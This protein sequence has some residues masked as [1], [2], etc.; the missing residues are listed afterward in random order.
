MLVCDMFL[1]QAWTWTAFGLA[2]FTHLEI[3]LHIQINRAYRYV[4]GMCSHNTHTQLSQRVKSQGGLHFRFWYFW[5]CEKNQVI[6]SSFLT[7]L[8]A[9]CK[10][11]RSS[12]TKT[13]P[14]ILQISSDILKAFPATL[15]KNKHSRKYFPNLSSLYRGTL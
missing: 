3:C 13:L 8:H 5:N 11:R 12:A 9:N 14:S 1:Q 4:K 15:F 10:L 6:L 7:S 2:P